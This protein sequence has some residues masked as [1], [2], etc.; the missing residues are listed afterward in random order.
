MFN[1][2]YGTQSAN[3]VQPIKWLT[4][5]EASMALVEDT[6]QTYEYSVTA[7]EMGLETKR[8]VKLTLDRVAWAIGRL[9]LAIAWDCTAAEFGYNYVTAIY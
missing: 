6:I 9:E 7:F 1:I 5:I 2:N 3:K 8:G 4:T